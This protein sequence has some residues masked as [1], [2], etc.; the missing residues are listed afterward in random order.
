M[1]GRNLSFAELRFDFDYKQMERQL[2][3]I[4]RKALPAAAAGFL[5]GVAFDARD[6]MVKGLNEDFDRPN[7]FTKKAFA[8]VTAKPADGPAMWAQV[9][10]KDKQAEYLAFQ[11][12][13]GVRGKGDAGAG[14]YDVQ[15]W[16]EK[17]TRFGGVD[18]RFL[19]RLSSR[20]KTEKTK[21]Q[22]LRA[23]R[24]SMRGA[25]QPTRA[26]RW[27]VSSRNRPGIFFGEVDGVKGYWE[28]PKLTKASR[29]R[30]RGVV[31]VRPSG[32]NRPKLL[33]MMKDEV[34][35]EKLYRYDWYVREA[36]RVKGSRFHWDKNLKHQIGKLSR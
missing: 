29:V 6:R 7:N 24:I 8:V 12:F 11:I 4:A 3:G 5:N 36:F 13:G 32:N 9:H 2:E 20:N 21:R 16:A 33:M 23:K 17:T 35:Y 10:V 25:G 18:K 15:P 1:S 31:T 30:K 34:R 28:R 27:V 14:P 26:A 19:K 22:E